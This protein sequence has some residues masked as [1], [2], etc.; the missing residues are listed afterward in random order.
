MKIGIASDH[1][2][3]ELKE[4]LKTNLDGYEV[5]DYGTNSNE[6]VDYPDYGILLAEKV[7]NKEVKFGIAICGSGIGI[8]IACNKVKGIRCAKVSTI[9]EAIYTR[10]DNDANIVALS[11]EIEKKLA[12]EI[13]EKFLNTPFSND[14]RH[15]RRIEKIK[16][17]EEEHEC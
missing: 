11:S 13:T 6:S 4:Y 9:N 8:S 17:Y 14:E 3:Y 1:R 12:L 15:L 2:G 16:K 5:V 10:N 7:K